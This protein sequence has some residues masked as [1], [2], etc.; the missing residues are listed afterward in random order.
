MK[1][2]LRCKSETLKS[3]KENF[4]ICFILV[5]AGRT[6]FSSY[7][8]EWNGFINHLSAL[9]RLIFSTTIFS[10]L[11]WP[12]PRVISQ[13]AEQTS[14]FL[15]HCSWPRK[16]F[17]LPEISA[18]RAETWNQACRSHQIRYSGNVWNINIR[19]PEPGVIFHSSNFTKRNCCHLQRS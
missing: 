13:S 15:M 19:K 1:S 8:S 7:F 9:Q 14:D 2:A 10:A 6:F 5:L 16:Q 3:R 17:P 4:Y 11:V 18:E 12:Q